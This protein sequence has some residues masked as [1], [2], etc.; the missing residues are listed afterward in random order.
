VDARDRQRRHW[1]A[2]AQGWAA[3]LDWTNQNFRPVTDWFRQ[4]GGWKAGARVL[5][6]ACGAGYPAF[7]AADAVLP[8]GVV[9]ATDLSPE[10]VAVASRRASADCR[11]NI[12][13][14]EMDGDNLEFGDAE[15]DSVINAYGLMFSG[16]LSRAVSEGRR[17]LKPGGRF[18]C[19]TWGPVSENP[20][21]SVISEVAAGPLALIPP[22]PEAPGPFRLSSPG[23]MQ[24]LLTDAGFAD[25]HVERVYMSMGCASVEEYLQMFGD[26]AWKARVEALSDVERARF[27]EKLSLAS[28]PYLENGVFRLGATSICASACR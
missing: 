5:D 22:G 15:F 11:S 21:F 26:L 6:V 2:V 7:A 16:D 25:V 12:Q 4:S 23:R 28:A 18:A 19:A 14:A 17:V 9:V 3:W 10:M 13:F 27:L 8:D 24:S 20:F 1:Q